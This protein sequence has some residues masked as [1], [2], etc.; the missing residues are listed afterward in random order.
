MVFRIPTWM[1]R[2]A[3]VTS[4]D[5]HCDIQFF[6]NWVRIFPLSATESLYDW[7]V[8]VLVSAQI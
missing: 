3:N 6:L 4:A 2:L 5:M 8:G 1:G 7:Q